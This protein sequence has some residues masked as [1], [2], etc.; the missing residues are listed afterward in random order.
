MTAW[1]E[2]NEKRGDEHVCKVCVRELQ[3]FD[4]VHKGI[5]VHY[6]V[7]HAPTRPYIT[8]AS[9]INF[10][11]EEFSQD[12]AIPPMCK[13]V[14]FNNDFPMT[15][16][17]IVHISAVNTHDKVMN[18]AFSPYDIAVWLEGRNDTHMTA[19]FKSLRAGVNRQG[20]KLQYTVFPRLCADGMK[21]HNGLC[22]G[23]QQNWDTAVNALVTCGRKEAGPAAYDYRM[24]TLVFLRKNIRKSD[25][26]MWVYN[27]IN[28]MPG[29]FFQ[30][31]TIVNLNTGERTQ[32]L[33]CNDA[34]SRHPF[35]CAQDRELLKTACNC[36]NGGECM[37]ADGN[38]EDNLDRSYYNKPICK[39][40]PGFVGPRCEE[41]FAHNNTHCD[42]YY[43][44]M[45]NYISPTFKNQRWYRFPGREMLEY[46]PRRS[47]CASLN[48]ARPMDGEMIHLNVTYSDYLSTNYGEGFCGKTETQVAVQNCGDF[49]IY[50]FTRAPMENGRRLC[51][52]RNPHDNED[53]DDN[54]D[55]DEEKR[56]DEK[57]DDYNDDKKDDDK[58]DEKD[59]DDE[60][61]EEGIRAPMPQP[62]P[63][64]EP[65]PEQNSRYGEMY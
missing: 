16:D 5:K 22:Y 61:K 65:E 47:G 15:K 23:K 30:K 32:D 45:N 42:K 40:K 12:Q 33:N 17:P 41:R 50:K 57:D 14:V 56:M 8:E 34:G 49:N 3:N 9:E 55:D 35:M 39:C 53:N 11:A 60:K 52:E 6:M 2:R 43:K 44:Y 13:T 37:R 10:P 25:N 48:G 24:S 38:M 26:V 51:L 27:H 54:D 58:D 18:S 7:I 62:E 4:G 64:P 1:V 21:Y 46:C 29:E 59:D 19:C 36:E 28:T 63:E 20:V 31:C